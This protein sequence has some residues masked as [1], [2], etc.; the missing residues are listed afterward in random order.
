MRLMK[1]S[2][3]NDR[4]GGIEGLP[5]Q[6]LIMVLIAGIG[7]AV[8]LSWMG[9]LQA[10][11]TISSVH[12]SADEIVLSDEDG[13]GIYS[14]TDISLDITVADQ[15]GDPIKGASVVLDG[16]GL[17]TSDGLRPHGSTDEQGKASFDGLKAAHCGESVSFVTISV[18][19]SGITAS[20]SITIPVICE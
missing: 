3:I 11:S 4:N 15:N 6:L 13:D 1:K 12:A 7:S 14:A 17:Q 20:K 19:K 18:V 16:A 10:P 5:L 8:I 9:G 2:M